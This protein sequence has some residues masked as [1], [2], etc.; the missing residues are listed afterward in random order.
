MFGD[1][2]PEADAEGVVHYTVTVVNKT[3]AKEI[4][5]CTRTMYDKFKAGRPDMQ[6][7]EAYVLTV[8]DG[9]VDGYSRQPRTS[10]MPG[11]KKEAEEGE[12][13]NGNLLILE[14]YPGGALAPRYVPPKVPVQIVEDIQHRVSDSDVELS[15]GMQIGG[16]TVIKRVEEQGLT[17]LYV[18]PM[19]R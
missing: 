14:L 16:Y 6:K 12:K 18:D 13:D 17:L 1:L 2:Q 19:A 7:K 9:M 11:F 10:N 4:L 3:G 8:V 15:P 5:P